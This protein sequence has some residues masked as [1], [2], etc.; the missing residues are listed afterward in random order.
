MSQNIFIPAHQRI[1]TEIQTGLSLSHTFT[2]LLPSLKGR[3][4]IKSCQQS[5]QDHLKQFSNGW[6]PSASVH[7]L[8]TVGS[9]SGE[10]GRCR[11]RLG[12]FFNHATVQIV[13]KSDWERDNRDEFGWKRL[14]Q[15]AF[16][17]MS[18]CC[19]DYINLILQI[20]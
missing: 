19:R 5:E 20:W 6:L 9:H 4:P 15:D 8:V 17:T 12:P 10:S 16:W 7:C 18:D 3:F 1:T 14:N 2:S 13:S 11:D